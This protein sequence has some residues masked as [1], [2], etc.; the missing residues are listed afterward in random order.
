MRQFRTW[1]MK[2]L[3]KLLLMPDYFRALAKEWLNILFGETLVGIGF[4]IWWALG[5]PTNH[6]LVAV[7]VIAMFV[8][9]YYAWRAD[10][11]RLGKRLEIAHLRINPW[12]A[13]QG[14]PNAGHRAKTYYF[15]VANRSEGTTI[16]G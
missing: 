4:L 11:L 14:T 5:A 2:Q 10:H 16:E 9:G 3:E 15:G 7:F 1:L 8:A 13:A 12:V 6:A